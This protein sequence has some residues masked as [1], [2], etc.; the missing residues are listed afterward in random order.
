MERVGRGS[1]AGRKRGTCHVTKK[2]ASCRSQHPQGR[3]HLLLLLTA[4]KLSPLAHFGRILFR[5]FTEEPSSW[6]LACQPP[7]TARVLCTRFNVTVYVAGHFKNAARR[8]TLLRPSLQLQQLLHAS[9]S[10]IS[11]RRRN[12]IFVDFLVSLW[13]RLVSN[14]DVRSMHSWDKDRF[15]LH[16]VTRTSIKISFSSDLAMLARVKLTSVVDTR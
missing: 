7:S 6:L 12:P 16:R 2:N 1:V 8:D 10:D 13:R 3:C 15:I 9:V 11:S 5:H 4:W 14:D